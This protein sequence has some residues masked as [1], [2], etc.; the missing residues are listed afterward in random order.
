[1]SCP[2]DLHAILSASINDLQWALY[3]CN[4]E[5]KERKTT[6]DANI[7][8]SFLMDEY[9]QISE[10]LSRVPVSAGK[11]SDREIYSKQPL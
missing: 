6:T 3:F 9:N 4:L 2:P 5:E 10:K 1:M 8:F 7:I 11:I